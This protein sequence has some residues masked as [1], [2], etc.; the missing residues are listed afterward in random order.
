MGFVKERKHLLK[1]DLP[2]ISRA[3]NLLFRLVSYRIRFYAAEL[4]FLLGR[5]RQT[6]RDAIQG[7]FPPQANRF[8]GTQ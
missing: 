1:N 3:K 2:I 6:D 7:R 4:L 5:S 8:A